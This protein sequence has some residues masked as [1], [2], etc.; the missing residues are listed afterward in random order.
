MLQ[1]WG[2]LGKNCLQSWNGTGCGGLISRDPG[3]WLP[4]WYLSRQ[5]WPGLKMIKCQKGL[6]RSSPGCPVLPSQYEAERVLGFWS[7]PG[8]GVQRVSAHQADQ[9]R[10]CLLQVGQVCKTGGECGFCW[11][12]LCSPAG[13]RL[14]GSLFPRLLKAGSIVCAPLSLQPC[15]DIVTLNSCGN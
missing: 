6:F 9:R 5:A 2:A 4:C 11:S 12:S 7:V 15:A 10:E 3:S 14:L 1:S 13:Q 8:P